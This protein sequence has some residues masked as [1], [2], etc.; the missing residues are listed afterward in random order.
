M[1][2]DGVLSLLSVELSV[3]VVVEDERCAVDSLFFGMMSCEARSM[4]LASRY[5]VKSRVECCERGR[6]EDERGHSA[7]YAAKTI[8]IGTT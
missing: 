6:A 8:Y 4:P 1:S 7:L 2:H 5:H 3:V